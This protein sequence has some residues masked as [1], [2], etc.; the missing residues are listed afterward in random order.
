MAS[1]LHDFQD[2]DGQEEYIVDLTGERDEV[3][4]KIQRGYDVQD[5]PEQ[6]EFVVK[7]YPSVTHGSEEQSKHFGYQYDGFLQ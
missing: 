4:N 3:R 1:L 6:Q 7:T 5:G 2:N